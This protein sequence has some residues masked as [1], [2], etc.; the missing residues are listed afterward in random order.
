MTDKAKVTYVISTYV[1]ELQ[2]DVAKV[3]KYPVSDALI[4]QLTYAGE[5][6]NLRADI[7]SGGQLKPFISGGKMTSHRH[8]IHEGKGGAG[9]LKLWCF[10]ENRY[11]DMSKRADAKRMEDYT[12]YSV[13]AGAEGVGA[14]PGYMGGQ[15]IHI[16][17][18]KRASWG[19]ASWISRALRRGVV[20]RKQAQAE[21]AKKKVESA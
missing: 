7:T 20:M 5:K 8:D 16:G 15:T 18:G 14:G 12:A 6:T 3:R 1:H 19:G 4:E 10:K 17:G 2:K 21:I 11:L 13:A 9:D